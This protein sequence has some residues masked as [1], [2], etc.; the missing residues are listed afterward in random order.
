MIKSILNLL[1]YLFCFSDARNKA[2]ETPKADTL[3][4]IDAKTFT[5]WEL[6]AATRNFRQECLVGE[7]AFGRVY[8]GKLE[9]T[10]Q[11]NKDLMNFMCL[12]VF[13]RIL[14]AKTNLSS[15][16]FL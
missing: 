10:G 6:A 15:V 9:S 1:I 8:K 16:I 13:Y 11:V 5:F 7:G 3:P 4:D 12:P 14:A 2:I